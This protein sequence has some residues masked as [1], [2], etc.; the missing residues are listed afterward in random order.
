MHRHAAQNGNGSTISRHQEL[1]SSRH[2]E[3][4]KKASRRSG[5]ARNLPAEISIGRPETW[6]FYSLLIIIRT[7][8]VFEYLSKAVR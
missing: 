8:I 7:G 1:M 2:Q 3:G 4:I 5:P 6:A